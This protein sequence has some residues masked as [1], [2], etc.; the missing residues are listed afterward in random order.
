[1]P[2]RLGNLSEQKATTQQVKR[3]NQSLVLQAIYRQ[4]TISRAAIARQT[5]LTRPAVSQIV[6]ELIEAGLVAEVGQGESS[7][8][9]RPTLLSLVADAYHVIGV[10]IGGTSTMGAVTD[11][12]GRILARVTRP[13]DRHDGEAALDTLCAVLDALVARATSPLL[14][15]GVSTPGLVDPAGGIVRYAANLGWQDFDLRGILQE[16]YSAPIYVANDTNLAAFGERFFGA[17]CGVSD[18]IIVMIGAGIGAG[19]IINGEIYHG[20]GGAAGEIGHIP[21][22]ENGVLCACGRRGCLETVASGRAM[23]ARARELAAAHPESLLN[24]L[25]SNGLSGEMVAR[26]VEAGDAVALSLVKEM[27]HYLGLAIA[28]L[29][30]VLNP[31]RVVIGGKMAG[32]GEPLLASIRQTVQERALHLLAMDVEIVPSS[33][34]GDVSILGAVAQVLAQELGIV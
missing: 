23:L 6:G 4:E 3:H 10:D 11:L 32:L 12:R 20:A 9:K 22:V 30:N 25:S 26:A 8:G 16:R 17:G 7:G 5:G 2:V 1:M 14:G 19:L 18:M 31:Q 29:V 34:G 15:I 13:M 28:I 24:T 21:V 33:L 27:G